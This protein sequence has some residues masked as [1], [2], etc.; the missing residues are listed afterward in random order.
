MKKNLFFVAILAISVTLFTSCKKENTIPPA[1]QDEMSLDWGSIDEKIAAF[2][3]GDDVST[4]R[5]CPVSVKYIYGSGGSGYHNPAGYLDATLSSFYNYH[6]NVVPAIV[7]TTFAWISPTG[8]KQKRVAKIAW[9]MPEGTDIDWVS[10]SGVQIAY[11]SWV[12]ADTYLITVCGTVFQHYQFGL[13]SA[14]RGE[15]QDWTQEMKSKNP[16]HTDGG[17][18][19]K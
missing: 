5:G 15:N 2:K 7:T 1:Q 9:P 16:S 11:S 8:P 18:I 17:E 6:A 4:E 10:L 14:P 19:F 12:T 3:R 13:G